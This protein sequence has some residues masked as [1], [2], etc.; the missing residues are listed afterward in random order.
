MEWFNGCYFE[1]IVSYRKADPNLCSSLLAIWNVNVVRF[2]TL[3]LATTAR[4]KKRKSGMIISQQKDLTVTIIFSVFLPKRL[5]VQICISCAVLHSHF[6][7]H[8][9]AVSALHQRG[10]TSHLRD[11]QCL[12]AACMAPVSSHSPCSQERR[13]HYF[14]PPAAA[15]LY[16]EGF[17]KHPETIFLWQEKARFYTFDFIKEQDFVQIIG[18]IKINTLSF[19][20]LKQAYFGYLAHTLFLSSPYPQS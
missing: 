13:Q 17:P 6:P 9:H 8:T 11:T 18:T 20:E 3:Q 16:N 10:V 1:I 19:L 5:C 2:I 7:G 12:C 14:S 15:H 4:K